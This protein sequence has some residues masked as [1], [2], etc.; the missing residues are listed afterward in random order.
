MQRE[1]PGRP[2][3]LGSGMSLRPARAFLDPSTFRTEPLRSVDLEVR[4]GLGEEGYVRRASA[5]SRFECQTAL[6][7]FLLGFHELRV[8]EHFPEERRRIA[9]GRFLD[10]AALVARRSR[11][12]SRSVDDGTRLL[13][14]DVPLAGGLVAV[15]D[16]QPGFRVRRGASPCGRSPIL[17]GASPSSR[18]FSSPF[19]RPRRRPDRPES[20]SHG[21]RS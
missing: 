21:P 13:V 14:G 9:V 12:A 5:G 2:L 4:R 8:R 1:G 3:L 18:N 7:P 6:F 20:T 11:R 15:L 10:V 19:A 17:P 16:E